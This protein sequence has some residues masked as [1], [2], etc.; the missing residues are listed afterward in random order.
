MEVVL[1]PYCHEIVRPDLNDALVVD[2]NHDD[3]D[4]APRY[5]H[6]ECHQESLRARD[7]RMDRARR[8]G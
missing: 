5:A 8:E 3:P 1:C 6:L 2:L 4:R 7:E